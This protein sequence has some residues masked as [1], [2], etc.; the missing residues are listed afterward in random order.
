MATMTLVLPR[1]ARLDWHAMAVAVTD[2]RLERLWDTGDDTYPWEGWLWDVDNLPGVLPAFTALRAAQGDLHSYAHDLRR[3]IEGGSSHELIPVQLPHHSVWITGGPST[4]DSPTELLDPLIQLAESGAAASAGF[5]HWTGYA[6]N[7]ISVRRFDFT[8]DELRSVHAGVA[9]GHVAEAAQALQH[10]D[11]RASAMEWLH[12]LRVELGDDRGAFN[13]HRLARFAARAVATCSWLL[14]PGRPLDAE[15]A[16]QTA[17]DVA[18]MMDEGHLAETR[19]ARS[20]RALYT[21]LR[22][23]TANLEPAFADVAAD[24]VSHFDDELYT[25]PLDEDLAAEIKT[26][27][28]LLALAAL[29]DLHRDAVYGLLDEP[30]RSMGVDPPLKKE[31]RDRALEDVLTM[32]AI[33]SSFNWQ[34]ASAV[35]EAQP[36]SAREELLADLAELAEATGGAYRRYSTV[37]HFDDVSLLIAAR[38]YDDRA[39]TAVAVERLGDCGALEAGAALW[40]NAPG[41]RMRRRRV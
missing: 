19:R 6:P 13:G 11:R 21:R 31:S 28:L 26:G 3:A 30:A 40:W 16:D 5:T 8:A 10:P 36:S 23:A 22:A 7:A 34:A 38:R 2:V 20:H 35:I 14:E 12:T 39:E 1:D 24:Q 25:F 9:L 18:L 17:A 33:D 41:A 37:E 32:L 4:G 15:H 29:A 27:P